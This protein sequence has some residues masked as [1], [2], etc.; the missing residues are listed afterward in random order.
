M[1]RQIINEEDIFLR[2]WLSTGDLKGQ[3]ESEIIAVQDQAL[4][5]K[6]HGEKILQTETDSKCRLGKQFDETVDHIRMSNI[7]KRTIYKET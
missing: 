4:Q 7:C 2:I 1:D 3:T 6:Y 5:T